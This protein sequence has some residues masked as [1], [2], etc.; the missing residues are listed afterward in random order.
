[1]LLE[2]AL[3]H[4]DEIVAGHRV[5]LDALIDQDLDFRTGRAILGELRPQDVSGDSA[6]RGRLSLEPVD[7]GE[8]E[9][10]VDN[11]DSA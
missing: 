2:L 5:E 9:A 6:R 11:L 8:P 7:V 4:F 3:D 1:V 10:E